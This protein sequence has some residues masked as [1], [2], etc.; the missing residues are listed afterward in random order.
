MSIVLVSAPRGAGKTSFIRD[1]VAQQADRGQS[2]GG[3][4]SP[5]VFENEQRIGYDL[6]DLRHGNRRLL[7]RVATFDQVAPTVGVFQFDD[8]AVTEGNA[9][10]CSAVRDGLEVIAID[11]VGP[12]EF[13]GR[14]WAPALEFA[15]RECGPKQ[16][17]IIVA[18]PSLTEGLPARFA[19]P[20][21][22]NARHVSPPWPSLSRK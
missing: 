9:A 19:S 20:T 14:G 6:I 22:A 8:A 18:R 3:I 4:A 2:V 13:R 1:Y 5:V 15:L 17:L 7:A 16:E 21:W 10:I 12:L 11:E